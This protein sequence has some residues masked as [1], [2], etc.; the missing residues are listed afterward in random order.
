MCNKYVLYTKTMKKI[1]TKYSGKTLHPHST[2]P[3]LDVNR[4]FENGK[5]ELFSYFENF[6]L[7]P[8]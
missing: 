1:K 8:G 2:L 4:G 3:W 6:T 5:H 7:W